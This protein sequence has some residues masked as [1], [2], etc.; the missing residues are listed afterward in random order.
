MGQDWAGQCLQ[1]V[2]SDEVP[3]VGRCPGSGHGLEAQRG[4]GDIPRARW[5]CRREASTRSTR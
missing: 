5:P 2:G 1:V 4:P 3:P